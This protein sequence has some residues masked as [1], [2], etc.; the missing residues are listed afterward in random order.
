MTRE[1]A[2]AIIEN[3]KECVNRAN[4]NDYCNRDCYNC[5]LVKTDTEIL[6]ALDMAIEALE[7]EPCEDWHDVPSDEMTLGQARQAVKDLRKKL[8]EYLRPCVVNTK[9]LSD[10]EIKKF[11]EEM[12]KVR[13]QVI[14]KE[15]CGDAISR[16]A[17]IDMTGLSE[18]FDSSDSYNGFVIAL[19]ELP[20]VTL[21]QKTGKWIPVSERLPEEGK[22]VMAST[23]YGIY[24]EA[25]YSEKYGWKWPWEVGEDYW[26]EIVDSVEAWMP[27][28]E[29]YKAESEGK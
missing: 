1:E 16:Q 9:D 15:P 12:K 23:N 10:D 4:K 17:V 27:L 18:W 2:I 13:V 21:K 24:P 8:A 5:E 22:T 3:E 28:P 14:P 19:S 29:P 11:V 25:R 26:T 6:T 7:Q 20:S